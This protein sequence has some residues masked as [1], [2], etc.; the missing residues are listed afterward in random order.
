MKIFFLYER[1]KITQRHTLEV[2]ATGPV[3]RLRFESKFALSPDVPKVTFQMFTLVSSAFSPSLVP[4]LLPHA[5]LSSHCSHM[6]I[7]IFTYI[8]I[9]FIYGS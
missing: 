7:F 3:S 9:I 2:D 4:H 6:F 8:D 5:H 1:G